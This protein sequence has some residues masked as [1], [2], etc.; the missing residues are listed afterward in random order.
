[1]RI[2]V[3]LGYIRQKFLCWEFFIYFCHGEKIKKV[4]E[5]YLHDYERG[6]QSYLILK[7]NIWWNIKFRLDCMSHSC[8]YIFAFMAS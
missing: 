8:N 7:G 4:F 6:P 2:L 3:A 1:M 5:N